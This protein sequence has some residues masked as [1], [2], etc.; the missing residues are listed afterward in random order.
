MTIS[1]SSKTVAVFWAISAASQK[2]FAHFGSSPS[3]PPSPLSSHMHILSTHSEPSTFS[4]GPSRISQPPP[5][6][7]SKS[8]TRKC[9][10]H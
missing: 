3:F 8:D 2:E 4:F 7:A 1:L 6:E 10:S 9:P 5:K